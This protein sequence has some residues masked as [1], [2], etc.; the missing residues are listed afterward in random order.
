MKVH[1]VIQRLQREREDEEVV[2]I[3]DDN[4]AK[5]YIIEELP[6]L[7]GGPRKFKLKH[8]GTDTKS[9]VQIRIKEYEP[10]E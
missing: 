6:F 8:G 10:S 5:Y 4:R 2:L 3:F 9:V 7:H 1:N